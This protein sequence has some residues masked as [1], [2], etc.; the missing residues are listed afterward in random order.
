[1]D[2]I[3]KDFP[4]FKHHPDVS[5]LDNAATALKPQ[6]VIDAVVDY[7]ER[8]SSNI[9]RGDYNTS[10]ETSDL[11]EA[12]RKKTAQFIKTTP[13]SIIFTSGASESLNLVASG[14]AKYYLKKGDVV[15]LNQAEHASNILPWYALAEEVGFCVE[16]IPLDDSGHITHEMLASAFHE[17]VK[18]VSMAHVSNV[19]GYVND[20][21]SF[22]KY[23]HDH[24]ALFCLDAAQS[25]GHMSIDVVDLDV[26][27][28]AFSAHK[29]LGPTG[30][31]VLYAKP[32]I[33]KKMYP[34]SH[35]G[36]SNI[37]FDA[38]GMVELK[39]GP[40]KFE[41]GTPNI[42]GVLGFGAAIDYL[43]QFG[44]DRI[45]EIILPLH[46]RAL[47]A[48]NAMDH[49]TVYNQHADMGLI[50]FSVKGIF[51][52]DVAAYLNREDVSVRSG[53]HC[54]KLINGALNMEKSVRISFYFYNND[55]DVTKLIKALETITLE[56]CIDL[57][58]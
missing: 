8:L 12:V 21:K 22:A 32:E 41:A 42:E 25:I 49:I 48:L 54:A 53:E 24:G 20:I 7:Y 29:M 30:V 50:T 28:M 10:L 39:S 36:G 55:A 2:S 4:F 19:L 11:Y 45:H 37:R 17:N 1:M 15:L 56:K 3:K 27:F 34:I 44:M 52:Q 16:F 38:C 57:Y 46:K 26:D 13:D 14:Y 33:Q 51:A 5:Y 43:N 47:D 40:A 18:V 9:H 58:L 6:T 31:G 35:G 23:A